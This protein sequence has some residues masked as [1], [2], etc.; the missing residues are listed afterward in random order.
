[1][2][3]KIR[4]SKHSKIQ[5]GNEDHLPAVAAHIRSLL[6][7]P[8]GQRFSL[9]QISSQNRIAEL[10][11]AFPTSDNPLPRIARALRD[12]AGLPMTAGLIP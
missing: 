7:V 1:M 2:P 6:T 10:E 5:L 4:S 11:F 9:N 3:F 8:L 12:H